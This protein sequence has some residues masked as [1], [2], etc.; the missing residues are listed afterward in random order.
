M[1]ELT[2][3]TEL[4]ECFALWLRKNMAAKHRTE[5]KQLEK[6]YKQ[7]SET[8]ENIDDISPVGAQI[9]LLKLKKCGR[10]IKNDFYS[11]YD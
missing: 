7:I 2:K 6:H 10:I 3:N 1:L 9:A 4:A 5:S 11:F 8:L